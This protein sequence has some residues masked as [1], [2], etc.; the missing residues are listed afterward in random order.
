MAAVFEWD[1]EKAATNLQKHGI[2]FLEAAS[3]FQDP[4]STTIRDPDQSADASD[5]HMKKP[6]SNETAAADEARP[7]Y[8]FSGGVRGKYAERVR[9]GTNLVLLDPEIA[10]AFPDSASVNKALRGLLSSVRRTAP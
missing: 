10:E 8:E 4:L 3:V 6:V 1:N 7:E 2:S 9:S 5:R